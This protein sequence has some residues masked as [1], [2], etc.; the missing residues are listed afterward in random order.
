MNRPTTSTS[1]RSKK[2]DNL[3]TSTPKNRKRKEEENKEG[4][5][6]RTP[7]KRKGKTLLDY[8]GDN[9]YFAPLDHS[10]NQFDDNKIDNMSM[11]DFLES[12]EED[13]KNQL[14]H[15]KT[16]LPL[17]EED[18]YALVESETLLVTK[19]KWEQGRK[20]TG[21]QPGDPSF[22]TEDGIPKY[23]RRLNIKVINGEKLS[24]TRE[25]QDLVEMKR[26]QY[27]KE[28]RKK[29]RN[30]VKSPHTHSNKTIR[31]NGASSSFSSFSS[32]R[33]GYIP[34]EQ[35]L[36]ELR[37]TI[38][39]QRKSH[40]KI[41]KIDNSDVGDDTEMNKDSSVKPLNRLLK[42]VSTSSTFWP[43]SNM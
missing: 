31:G 16:G 40:E 4:V 2:T 15:W 1:K 24:G 23:L 33:W 13:P 5:A 9:P 43:G 35:E 34:T 12:S 20:V 38:L 39:R 21:K 37:A 6:D 14:Y 3:F 28:K 17:Y 42:P 22:Y 8:F 19:K 25:I 29:E 30:N 26:S 32:S 41:V 11:K 27:E 10:G 7:K 18:L 36:E